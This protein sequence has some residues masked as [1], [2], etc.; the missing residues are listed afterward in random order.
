MLP[1]TQKP[2]DF[3]SDHPTGN[4]VFIWHNWESCGSNCLAWDQWAG[5]E[6]L[7]TF[8]VLSAFI[9]IVFFSEV[10]VHLWPLALHS[11][12]VAFSQ[13]LLY[14]MLF[15]HLSAGVGKSQGVKCTVPRCSLLSQ[16]WGGEEMD[17]ENGQWCTN[18]AYIGV[19][20]L[21]RE[22]V[23]SL[24]HGLRSPSKYQRKSFWGLVTFV[25]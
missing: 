1:R 13:N 18:C 20:F 5:S 12:S 22:R 25:T 9:F 19:H 8:L 21:K 4:T 2:W 11:C 16:N 15:F 7:V 14:P 23:S 6:L 3:V 10:Y 24:R 17:E